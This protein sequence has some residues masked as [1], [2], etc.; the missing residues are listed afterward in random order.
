[1]VFAAELNQL[2]AVEEAS[3]REEFY[4]QVEGRTYAAPQ[5]GQEIRVLVGEDL[6]QKGAIALSK[7]ALEELGIQEGDAVEVYGG[8][9][10]K[11]KT[12]LSSEKDI[13]LVR[14]AKEIR[15]ALPCEKGQYVGIRKEYKR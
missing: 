14:M 9:I 12:V 7:E 13:T 3:M 10:Q 5:Y 11:G 1:V 8:W 4:P 15:E 2:E 6:E